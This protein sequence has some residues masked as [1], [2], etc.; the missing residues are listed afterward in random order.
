[1][2]RHEFALRQGRDQLRGRSEVTQRKSRRIASTPEKTVSRSLS[3][4]GARTPVSVAAIERPLS[5]WRWFFVGREKAAGWK[6]F[7]N[8]WLL[9]H[10]AVGV[11]GALVIKGSVVQSAQTVLLPLAGV[12][13]GMSFAWVGNIQGILQSEEA[14][15]LYSA[16]P[17]G[18]ENYAYTFQS[19]IL[20]VLIAISLWGVAGLGVFDQHCWW[21]CSARPYAILKF[22]LFFLISLA[23][24][25]CWHVVLGAQL[26]LLTQRFIRHLPHS[27]DAPKQ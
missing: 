23:I 21:N 24:R 13:V 25:E 3:G 7:I 6:K 5:Y 26:L 11:A 2:P 9:A 15:K 27:D 4:S 22:W 20:V 8:W 16:H 1:M 10:V 12:F 14:E 19:A 17:G 18:A